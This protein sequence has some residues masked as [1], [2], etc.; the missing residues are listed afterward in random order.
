M[1]QQ[2]N[3]IT[4]EGK[5]RFRLLKIRQKFRNVSLF[6]TAGFVAV[7]VLVLVFSIITFSQNKKNSRTI[8][9][10]GAQ[11]SGQEK[12]ESYALVSTNRIKIINELFKT[13]TSYL[14]KL[15]VIDELL[16]PGFSLRDVDFTSNK[17]L[18]I[19]GSCDGVQSLTNFNQKIEE[20]KARKEFSEVLISSASRSNDGQYSIILELKE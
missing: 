18:K 7:A 15:A 17:V 8:A 16:V 19:T 10:L 9:L 14:K 11:I 13:R 12:L 1:K 20:I 4:E 6:L 2:I 3:L 5:E